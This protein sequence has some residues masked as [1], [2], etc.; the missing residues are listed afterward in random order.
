MGTEASEQN[1]DALCERV[2]TAGLLLGFYFFLV[3]IYRRYYLSSSGAEDS[4]PSVLLLWFKPDMAQ[5]PWLLNYLHTKAL[6]FV[7]MMICLVGIGACYYRWPRRPVLVVLG[8]IWLQ[9]LLYL[10]GEQ[11]LWTPECHTLLLLTGF[12]LLG[13]GSV[14][15]FRTG[16]A[17]WCVLAG[18]GLL[19]SSR[20]TLPW[21]GLLGFTMVVMGVLLC[22]DKYQ[23]SVLKASSFVLFVYGWLTF[24]EFLALFAL[25][26]V[27]YLL[28]LPKA[29][30]SG[31][32]KPLLGLGGFLLLIQLLTTPPY[33]LGQEQG[34]KLLQPLTV[35]SV[36]ARWMPKGGAESLVLATR[37]RRT[38]RLTF[39]GDPLLTTR[40]F[41]N[42]TLSLLCSEHFY[43]VHLNKMKS[44][45]PESRVEVNTRLQGVETRRASYP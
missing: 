3:S 38:P 1:P 9:V 19:M 45:Y 8:L 42:A 32:P 18:T 35:E 33:W 4:L 10:L 34:F 2:L 6:L 7:W 36:E 40:D 44:S 26:L 13:R 41:R 16:L 27:A 14:G 11:R 22:L 31:P 37:Y 12:F 28:A 29:E 15:G 43:R 39:E 5:T 30:C 21:A 25:L 24:R 20:L 17:S 23:S